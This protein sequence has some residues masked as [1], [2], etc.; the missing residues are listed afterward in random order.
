MEIEDYL[1][2]GDDTSLEELTHL[3]ERQRFREKQRVQKQLEDVETQIQSIKSTS[4]EN[5]SRLKNRLSRLQRQKELVQ[6]PG[7]KSRWKALSDREKRDIVNLG[8]KIQD[9]W[10]RLTEEKYRLHEQLEKP[11]REK[12]ELERE[13]RE[14]EEASVQE[15]LEEI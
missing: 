11:L 1:E 4:Q 7:V 15:L 9:L 6:K 8:D 5:T 2:T 13:L 14:L 3:L 12:R 10:E